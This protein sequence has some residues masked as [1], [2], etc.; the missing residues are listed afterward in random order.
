MDRIE[1]VLLDTDLEP[2]AVIDSYSSFIWTDRFDEYGDFEIYIPIK[3]SLPENIKKGYYLWNRHS[4]H[5]M[6]IESITIDSDS[7]DGA[8]FIIMGR[9]LES[10]LKRRIVWNKKIFAADDKGNLPNLQNGIKTILEENV[11]NPVE[12][13]KIPNFIFEES[14]DEKITS[15]TLEAQYLGEEIY[16]VVSTLCKENEI[17]FKVTLNENNQ[18]VFKLYAGVD[19]T[20]NQTENTYVI[21]S[22]KYDNVM[23]TNYIDS[24]AALKNVTLVVG[25]SEYDEDGNEVSRIQHILGAATGLE[26]R[27]VFT[28]ALSLSR[29]DGYGGKLSYEQ[30]DAHLKQKGID[31]L[32]DN[33]TI[34]AFEGEVDPTRMFVYGEDYF[35]GDIVQLANEYG[36]E[37][38]AY[39]SEFI[40]SSDQNGVS[41]YPTFKSIQKGVYET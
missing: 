22:P 28:D 35:I 33:T 15:L 17:G 14:T 40:I 10:I 20:Y 7:E 18:F 1:A 29:D 3:Q 25:E 8:N 32:I 41:T 39:I 2:I 13:R 9:S 36:Q 5:V 16:E 19:R 11:I 6:I 21:F 4:E 26:R 34:T 31:T 12:V 23:S 27:E 37:G 24:D 38:T 30:Y